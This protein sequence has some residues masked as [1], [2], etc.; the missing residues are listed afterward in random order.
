MKIDLLSRRC[1]LSLLVI[2]DSD[3]SRKSER[4][5]ASLVHDPGAGS[6]DR[7]DREVGGL[8]LPNLFKK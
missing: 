4:N 8:D 3:E 1:I 5:A 7:R 6:V 2:S